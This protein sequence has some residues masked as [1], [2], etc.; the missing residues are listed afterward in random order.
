MYLNSSYSYG[1]IPNS[2]KTGDVYYDIYKQRHFVYNLYGNWEML[3]DFNKHK[4]RIKKIKA[5]LI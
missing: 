1:Y 5:I 2:P 4:M 3:K